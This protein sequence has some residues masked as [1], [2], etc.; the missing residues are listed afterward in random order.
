MESV[1]HLLTLFLKISF[2]IFIL[3]LVIWLTSTISRNSGNKG[4]MSTSTN[5]VSKPRTDILPS[6]RKYS[7]FFTTSGKGVEPVILVTPE[8]FVFEG[9]QP[10]SGN[11]AGNGSSIGNYSTY[12]Y[13]NAPKA[14]TGNTTVP[15]P[16]NTAVSSTDVARSQYIRNLSIYQGGH[17]YTGLTFVGEARTEFFRDG[18]FPIVVVDAS[19]KVVGISAALAATTWS[20]PGWVRFSTKINYTL[21]NK[22][23]CTMVFE[24]NLTQSERTRAPVRIPFPIM[25]N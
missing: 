24:E 8:P 11:V 4:E 6:P 14:A 9:E 10:F 15:P 13:S 23:P 5:T 16:T 12:T 17:I 18:K 19:G 3:V 1:R 21:P 20:V 2:G 25:C 7:G 22:V